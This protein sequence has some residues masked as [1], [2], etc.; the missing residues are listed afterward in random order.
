M[1][2]QSGDRGS[3]DGA[4]LVG[5]GLR[6]LVGLKVGLKEGE[7]ASSETPLGGGVLTEVFKIG[8]SGLEFGDCG[9]EVVGVVCAAEG[10]CASVK[11]VA[12]DLFDV[13]L[14]AVVGISA[15]RCGCGAGAAHAVDT[16]AVVLASP[17]AAGVE[18]AAHLKAAAC[19]SH[20]AMQQGGV[21]RLTLLAIGL[22]AA[23]G[24]VPQLVADERWMGM[25]IFDLAPKGD[26][27]IDASA[28][29][30][31]NV[32]MGPA[33]AVWSGWGVLAEPVGDA[34]EGQAIGAHLKRSVRERRGLVGYE[35]LAV[36]LAV[37]VGQAGADVHA[38]PNSKGQRLLPGLGRALAE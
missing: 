32:C 28:Q 17:A 23:L 22:H 34:L 21:W 10:V 4:K 15:D 31:L 24:S 11:F 7:P 25:A 33:V 6:G 5:A 14:K 16:A 27:E 8:R 3:M 18:G 12:D 29:H 1:C 19:A 38:A 20:D 36:V 37:A 2:C 35:A 30:A 13:S 26:A 9:G